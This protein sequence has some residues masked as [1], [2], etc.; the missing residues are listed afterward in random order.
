[1][2]FGYIRVSTVGQNTD[3]Q[4]RDLN[5]PSEALYIDHVSGKDTNR[6]ELQHLLKALRPGDIVH[7]HS[8]DRLARNLKDLMS[9][10]DQ[11]RNKGV[12]VRFHKENLTLSPD[13]NNLVSMLFVQ[14]FGALAEWELALQKER[15]AE[16][17][18]AAR[19]LGKPLG[20]PT[21]VTQEQKEAVK[22]RFREDIKANVARISRE[23]GVP[24]T[25]CRLLRAQVQKEMEG[26]T[27][28][29]G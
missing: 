15:Q 9:L 8:L 6:P 3:R 7:V 20:R 11:I 19:K 25:S 1:M 21:T 22:A 10:L 26:N 29:N 16:G 17:I 23:I 4:L 24:P 27:N 5:L 18:A 13:S 14:I 28:K 2:E 12:E